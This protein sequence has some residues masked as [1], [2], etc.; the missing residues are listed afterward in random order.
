MPRAKSIEAVEEIAESNKPK[1][2]IET[3]IVMLC[4]K[5][6]NGSTRD[7]FKTMEAIANLYNAV[8]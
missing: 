6:T 5:V 8:K 7:E 4:E 3:M 1:E 2:A